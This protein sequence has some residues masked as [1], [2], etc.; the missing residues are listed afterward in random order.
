MTPH[1]PIS[2][3]QNP[4]VPDECWRRIG[5]SG[6]RTCPELETFI[7]CRN[8]PILAAAATTFFNRNAPEGYLESWRAILEEPEIIAPADALS[9]LVFR[10][11]KEWMSLPTTA[12]VEVTT[13]R[14]L[15]RVPHRPS[16]ILEGL[17]NI[18]GQL[19]LCISLYGLLGLETTP[20]AYA[21]AS[22]QSAD[23]DAAF[24]PSARLLVVERSGERGL[25]RWVFRVDEVAGVQRIPRSAMR[26]APSTVSHA[27]MRSTLALFDWQGH[28]VGLLDESRV[29][30]GLHALI[31]S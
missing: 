11:D 2:E 19:Q 26:A 27:G 28:A 9:V 29:F 16:T 30:D 23:D 5:V 31:S 21:D 20:H 22:R 14:A 12:L 18:R 15:H 4:A 6:D 10:L 13:P 24:G 17:V 7:H 8:C 1:L 25:E 3:E